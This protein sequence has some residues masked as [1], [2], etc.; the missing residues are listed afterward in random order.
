MNVLHDNNLLNHNNGK[1]YQVSGTGFVGIGVGKGRIEQ[2]QDY[3]QAILIMEELRK[4]GSLKKEPTDDDIIEFAGTV[5]QLKNV[6]FF[7]SRKR[8]EEDLTEIDSVLRSKDLISTNDI[9]YFVGLEDMWTYGGIQERLY[10][11]QIKFILAPEVNLY[12]FGEP[13]I[14]PIV[15]N[16]NFSLKNVINFTSKKPVSLK[17]QRDFEIE[18]FSELSDFYKIWV[19]ENSQKSFY[20]NVRGKFLIGYYP[21]TRTYFNLYL[22]AGISY[23][24][25]DKIFQGGHFG[26]FLLMTSEGYYYISER[27]RIGYNLTSINQL[28]NFLERK[29]SHNKY[30]DFIYSFAFNYAIF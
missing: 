11:N 17:L 30:S 16:K 15:S 4:R 3:R 5:S 6:R 19:E 20:S 1:S 9:S 13:G 14:E 10:G 8:K 21:N 7:D 25:Y 22:D 26:S 12:R 18:L 27:L 24:G 29:N 28:S 2:V 23:H